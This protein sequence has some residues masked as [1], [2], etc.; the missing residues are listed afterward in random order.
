M[1]Y[2]YTRVSLSVELLVLLALLLVPSSGYGGIG[3]ARKGFVGIYGE[4]VST[5]DDGSGFQTATFRK[6]GL[7]IGVGFVESVARRV[8]YRKTGMRTA[9]VESLLALSR[10]DAAWDVWTPAGKKVDAGAWK[11]WMR[12]D[13][14]A[15]AHSGPDM[16][17]IVAGEWNRRLETVKRRPGAEA[18]ATKLASAAVPSPPS[19]PAA[20][21][22]YWVGRA[23][24]GEQIGV[25]FKRG[26]DMAWTV[27]G[28]TAQQVFETKYRDERIGEAKA[29]L[30]LAEDPARPAVTVRL[31]MFRS[32]GGNSL[33]F[34]PQAQADGTQTLLAEW[35]GA[36]GIVF[37]R[38][39]AL[40]RWTP[41]APSE[42]PV[43]G[44][45]RG[46]ALELLGEPL[47]KVAAG[48]VETLQ[49]AWGS[50]QVR[51]GK[52]VKISPSVG[53]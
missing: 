17:T 14:T 39:A 50:V 33:L 11:S 7:T 38:S 32:Q 24:T 4:P 23:R 41:N 15:M 40:P 45:T 3:M 48:G 13:E 47:G 31:G 49:Y 26:N 12:S 36:N 30:M 16:L 29:V 35:C 37:N 10:G 34:R 22:G 8:V 25:H 18:A 20:I 5:G 1:N 21:T 51:D 46:R 42:L 43:V 28:R 53:E 19:A 44:D 52:V 9:D 2:R 27:Y 6:G